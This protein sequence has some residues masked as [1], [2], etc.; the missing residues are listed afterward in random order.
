MQL[1]KQQLQRLSSHPAAAG[2]SH[3]RKA[4]GTQTG[5]PLP[6]AN[7]TAASASAGAVADVGSGG[8]NVGAPNTGGGD[9]GGEPAVP[10]DSGRGRL[11]NDN[12]KEH[13]HYNGREVQEGAECEHGEN[14]H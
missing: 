7:D 12:S 9:R 11:R 2:D 3:V 4:A 13:H 14:R 10:G 8:S 6:G 1:E 5:G